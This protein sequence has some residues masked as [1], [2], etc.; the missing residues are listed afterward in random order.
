[1]PRIYIFAD[2]SGNL[3]FNR[4]IGASRY[5]IICTVRMQ[6]CDVG[7][8]LLEL[9]RELLFERLPVLEEFHATQDKQAVRDRVF[10]VIANADLRV[11]ATIMEKSKSQPQVRPSA[12]RFYHYGWY[13]HFK[14]SQPLPVRTGSEIL[15]TTAKIEN[16]KHQAAFSSGVH[17]VLQQLAAGQW[18]TH[19]CRSVSDPCIQ[20]ADYCAWAIGRKWE[21]GDRRSYDLIKNRI[22]YEYDL[23]A[24]GTTHYF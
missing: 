13:Y 4:S 24:A 11:Q 7:N 17:D 20:V 3:L 6:S 23:W 22:T 9:R 15:V 18:R 21:S 19:F 14:H 5:F 1:M 10:G 8:Q 12:A 16:A 2:E